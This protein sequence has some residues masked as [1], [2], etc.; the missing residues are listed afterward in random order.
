VVL[1]RRDDP[2]EMPEFGL[3]CSVG[4]LYRGTTTLER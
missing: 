1:K 2:I 3:H 4:D